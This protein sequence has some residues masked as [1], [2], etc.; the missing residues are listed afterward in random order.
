M[1]PFQLAMRYVGIKELTGGKHHPLIQWWLSLCAGFDLD[2]ADETPWCSAFVNGIA[3]ELR[4]PRSNS[5]AARSWLLVGTPV[6]L[7]EAAVGYD[8]VILKRGTGKQPGPE[9]TSGA[10][11]H[12][13]FF[14]GMEGDH[15]LLLG[16]N[17]N[18]AVS[19]ARYPVSSVLGIRR[20][21]EEQV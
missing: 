2:A 14:A 16:G 4:L 17:Q 21:K 8:V 5:A 3:W 15:V 10:S 1:T 20:L 9:V 7:E 11:G 19:I 6:P 13:G 18:N 12:V